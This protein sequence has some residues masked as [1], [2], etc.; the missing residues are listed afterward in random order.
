MPDLIFNGTM[1]T[2]IGGIAIQM[3]NKTGVASVKGEIIQPDILVDNA[4]ILAT[5]VSKQVV[6]VVYE[7]GIPDGGLCYVVYLGPALVLL[8]DSTAATHGNW[9]VPSDVAGRVDA[10][11]TAPPGGLLIDHELHF[12]EVG[13]CME[14]KAGGT[15]VLAKIMIHLL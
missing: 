10:T 15:D 6:G 13:H 12:S 8:K 2:E 9:C 3:V 7:S 4:F 14:S 5:A 11:A 1:F